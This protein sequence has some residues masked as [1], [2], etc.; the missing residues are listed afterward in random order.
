MTEDSVARK[1]IEDLEKA[2]SQALRER[3]AAEERAAKAEQNLRDLSTQLERGDRQSSDLEQVRQRL[4]EEL[5]EERDRHVAD[6]A[7]RDFAMSQTQITY[8]SEC[9]PQF[10][11][12]HGADCVSL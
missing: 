1:A 2:H 12:Y 4:E 6:L 9:L 7:E 10:I 8:Q 11:A 3:K 5:H